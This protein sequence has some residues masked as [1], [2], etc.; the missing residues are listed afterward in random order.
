MASQVGV[1]GQQAQ[2]L[3]EVLLGRDLG[4]W[5]LFVER[6]GDLPAELPRGDLPIGHVGL[7]IELAERRHLGHDRIDGRLDIRVDAAVAG[8]A[9]LSE[10]SALGSSDAWGSPETEVIDRR[11]R[12]DLRT[13]RGVGPDDQARVDVR[14]ESIGPGTRLE[15]GVKECVDGIVRGRAAEVG[16]GHQ[17]GRRARASARASAEVCAEGSVRTDGS[18]VGSAPRETR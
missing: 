16:D 14:V 2:P 13:G 18:G 11:A 4:R 10:G 8:R 3:Q 15:P 12:R 6:L 5:V 7:G 1:L 17:V 9:R